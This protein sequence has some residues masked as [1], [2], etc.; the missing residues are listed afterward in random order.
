MDSPKK[1][2]VRNTKAPTPATKAER[3]ANQEIVIKPMASR[4]NM[5]K[6]EK[7]SRLNTAHSTKTSAKSH[8]DLCTPAVNSSKNM[9]A[10]MHELKENAP[11]GS[12]R[13]DGH[14]PFI[15]ELIT[16]SMNFP[17]NRAIFKDLIP[18]GEELKAKKGPTSS[19][20][21]NLDNPSPSAVSLAPT[22]RFSLSSASYYTPRDGSEYSCTK[23]T[24]SKSDSLTQE[25]RGNKSF[26]NHVCERK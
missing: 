22:S 12:A 5:K 20:K 7:S 19:T 4:E 2:L 25:F 1:S 3:A 15:S 18:L 10:Q 21:I 23:L 9:R 16:R 8:H 11:K 24:Y 6:S 26:W 13:S 14:T 17:H